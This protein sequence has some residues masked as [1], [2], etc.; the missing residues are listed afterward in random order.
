MLFNQNAISSGDYII[1]N[2]VRLRSAA[3]ANF[4]R[5]FGTATAR[6]TW[7]FS[8]WVKR[9]NVAGGITHP[10]FAQIQNNTNN[11]QIYFDGSKLKF[12]SESGGTV[13]STATS[14]MNFLDASAWY[15]IVIA[16]DTSQAVQ[17]DRIKLY[18]NGV[19]R[20]FSQGTNLGLNENTDFNTLNI[21]SIGYDV[22]NNDYFDGYLAEVYFIDGQGL[23]ASSFGDY[24]TLTGIWQP[25]TYTGTYGVNGFYL[26]FDDLT[27]T[28]TLG[29]DKSG[30]NNHWTAIN[31]SL[32]SGITYD[33]MIDSPTPWFPDTRAVGNYCVLNSFSNLT[34]VTLRNAALSYTSTTTG[35]NAIGT[36][37]M[38]T[39]KWYWEAITDNQTTQTRATVYGTTA[40]AYYAFASNNN[41]YGFR[42]D[43]DAGTLDYTTDGSSWTSLATGLTSGP[44]FPFFN[45]NGTN[46]KTVSVNFGQRPYAYTP[47]SGYRSLC[48]AN[49]PTPSI[50]RPY[51]YFETTL[52]TGTGAANSISN[53]YGF[54]PDLVWIKN[55]PSDTQENAL[56]DS[57]R[58]ATL[59]IQSSSTAAETTQ[60]Q[61]LTSFNSNG[62]SVG[63]LSRVN[64]SGNAMVAWQWDAGSSTVTNTDGSISSQVRANPTS[65]FSIVTYTGTGANATVGHGLGKAP[66]L[67]I[68]KERN[69]SDNWPV[70]H[71]VV[72]NDR[73]MTLNLTDARTTSSATYWNNT[74]PT[75][76]VFSLGTSG[77]SNAL[78]STYVAY[79]FA[80]ID[81]YSKFGSYVGN[82]SGSPVG[83][84]FVYL[85]FRPKFLLIKDS[86]A[87]A[88]WFIFDGVRDP[89][90][91]SLKRLEAN[92]PNN[93]EGLTGS[94]EFL[95]NGFQTSGTTV[96]LNVSSSTYIYI[97]FAEAPFKYSLAR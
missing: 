58:G 40:A 39:G 30:N 52:Y 46:S 45:N 76:S 7:T 62:F 15:H 26:K 61:G 64:Q 60:V 63:T 94:L 86:T 16:L 41:T 70:Y 20:T 55:R 87:S 50:I 2:S 51:Q 53:E 85:G 74:S 43:A 5:T 49:L 22:Q 81:G 54:S 37:G 11:A 90:N 33:A 18:V 31:V 17:A 88:D 1:R 44:Y 83:G 56:Y 19:Q 3:S 80:E 4:Q 82:N 66:A 42:F 24:N 72:G 95:S 59:E 23:T 9:G 77:S 65:G 69:A 89:I 13:T 97:A 79:C 32:T 71:Q 27:S 21:H 14:D 38:S 93:E 47:P 91:Q 12:R 92:T 35:Q 73:R 67:I 28:T 29:Y 68:I 96:P 57:V 6:N 48:T 84:P 34:T 10:I 8:A 36:F 75:S 78:G 25:K